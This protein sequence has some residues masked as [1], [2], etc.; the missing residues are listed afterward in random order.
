MIRSI[1]VLTFL[2]GSVGSATAEDIRMVVSRKD[3]ERIVK[4]T[5][6]PDVTYKPGVDVHGKPV[7]P[8]DLS[9][10]QI[11]I[12][13]Q[14]FI[15]LSLPFKDLLE[16]YNPKLKNAEVYVGT[17]EYDI[18]SGKLLF[19]GQELAD[20]AENAIARECRKRYQ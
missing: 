20:P 4:Y 8:A 7:A 13:D 1:L 9:G 16:N 19:N 18:A 17:V 6:D 10:S 2:I 5:P 14:I 3:C 11:Q 15:D 12:P